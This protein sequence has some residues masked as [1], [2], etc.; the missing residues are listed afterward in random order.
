M[1]KLITEKEEK[2]DT[3]YAKHEYGN[4]YIKLEMHRIRE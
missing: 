1:E 4:V 3:I 2:S